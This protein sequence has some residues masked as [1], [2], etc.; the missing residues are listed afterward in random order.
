MKAIFYKND[1][2]SILIFLVA[3]FV[4]SGAASS[5]RAQKIT[6]SGAVRSGE[7]Q[8]PLIGVSI[9]EQGGSGGA[10]TDVE[11]RFRLETDAQTVLVFTYTGFEDLSVPVAGQTTLDVVM[12]PEESLLQELVVTGYKR[13]YKSDVS[14]AI[15]SVKSK[16]IEKLVVLGIDQALQGQAAGVQITQTTGAP[17]DDIA[18]R[19]RG[20]GT[21]NNNNPLFIIDGVP[22]TGNINTFST[23]D[24]ESIEVLKDGA[25]AAIYGARAAN[26]VVLI[27]TKRGKAGKPQFSFDTYAGFS[28]PHRLPELLNAREYLEIRNEAI[29]NANTLR[30][31]PNQLPTYDLSMLDTLPDINWLDLIFNPAP[32]QR[33]ALSASGGNEYGAYFIQGEYLDQ[34]GIFKGQGFKKYGLRFNGE[35]GNG[36]LKFGNNLSFAF[37]DRKVINSSGD[38]FGPGNELS[39]VR[40][41][42]IAAPVFPIYRQDGSYYNVSSE[43]GDPVLFGD[44]N[45]NPLAFIDATDWTIQRSRFFG[46]VYVELNLWKNRLRARSSLGGDFMFENEKKFKQ[47]LSQAV[48][49]PSSLSEGRVFDRNLVWQNTIDYSQEFGKGRISA[50]AGMEA[51]QNNTNYL[52]ASVNN[53]RRTDPLF[54]YIDNAVVSEIDNVGVGGIVTEWALLSYFGQLGYTYDGRYVLN[55]TL[56]RDGSSRFGANN[57]W[58]LFPSVSAAWNVSNERF[59]QSVS[60]VSGLKF[61]ASWGRLGNQ[62]IGNYPY[63]SLIETGNFTYSFGDQ[64]VTGAQLVEGGNANI[65]WETTTQTNFGMDLS[66]WGE[67]LTF[68]VDYFDKQS[69]DILVRV[70]VPQSGGAQNPPFVN[71]A[72][73]ENKGWEFSAIYKTKRQD[74]NWSV[75]AN[76]TALRNRVISIAGGEPILGGFG[77]SD[78]PLTKTEPGHPIGSFFLWQMEGIFQSQ[79]EID[80]HAFQTSSTRPGDVK[81]ADLNDDGVIDDKDRAHLGNPFPDFTYGLNASLSWKNLDF[82][83]LAQGVQG[84]DLF[85]LYGNFAYETQL[86]GFNSYRDI[87]N[88]WTPENPSNTFP[89]VSVDDRNGNRRPSTRWLYDGSYLRLRNITLGYNFK[90]L[91]RTEAVGSLRAYATVQNAFTFTKYPGLDPEIQANTN[92]TRG[93]GISSDLAVGIDWGTVPAPRTFIFGI[94]M[95]F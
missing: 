27:T 71:A 34:E 63:S 9:R 43:L 31:L 10:I 79:E 74:F 29:N 28:Q 49:N 92:D 52:G 33:Y 12:R 64:I 40:Y 36:W 60:F 35:T 16:D 3:F 73:V 7:D 81:F 57:R 82:S 67:R 19:I 11:G 45:A 42:L 5:V 89:K 84:N 80:N 75:G 70:P 72:Q 78:G 24:I 55:A 46:N 53:F 93:L 25:A 38:G 13:E 39:G 21:L 6:V 50:L 1:V 65:R 62:E 47:R 23:L 90:H 15:T 87:L 95:Q 69:N 91:I 20:A 85:F 2:R 22:T 86:R 59:F 77:L 54:R 8:Q 37:T 4:F 32:M 41:T 94:Q 83:V 18:V 68:I 44:G 26:G 51:I 17:G 58:G 66:V 61:R 56:R 88:R 30:P 14:S 48:Y 76:L